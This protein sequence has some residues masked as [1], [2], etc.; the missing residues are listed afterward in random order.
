MT[1]DFIPSVEDLINRIFS[2]SDYSP[3]RDH[4]LAERLGLTGDARRE[5]RAVLRRME[6]AGVA[7]RIR[8]NRW[9]PVAHASQTRYVTGILQSFRRGDARVTVD[10]DSKTE[11]VVDADDLRGALHGDRVQIEP[12]RRPIS[13]SRRNQPPMAPQAGPGGAPVRARIVKV[14]ERRFQ[15]IP[16]LFKR[17]ANYSYLIPEDARL[18]QNIRITSS[19]PGLTPQDNDWVVVELA[20][21]NPNDPQLQGTLVEHLG[22]RDT[23]H[24]DMRALMV[25]HGL[26][27]DFPEAAQREANAWTSQPR[28]EDLA[29]RQDLREKYVVTI[30][31]EQ[32]RDFDDAV[33][34]EPMEG[35]RWRLG[36]HIADVAHFVR[37]GSAVDREALHRGTS[38]YLV[39]RAIPMLPRQLTADVCSLLP[40]MDRLTHTVDMVIGPDATVQSYETYPSVIRSCRRWNYDEVQQVI[41]SHSHAAESLHMGRAERFLL[42]L[43]Q[44]AL[45]LRKR[46]MD[47]G[48]LDFTLPEVKFDFDGN[49][50]IRSVRR[51]GSD[52]AYH[53]IEECMLLANQSVAR[54]LSGARVPAIYRIHEEPD[55]E[56]WESMEED[57]LLMG[58]RLRDHNRD[59]VN[60]MAAAAAQTN[61]GYTVAL[62]ILRNL[63]RAEYSPRCI[64]HFGLAFFPYTHFTSPIRRY[65]DLM[66][67]RM[68]NALERGERPPYSHEQAAAMAKQ[69]T[70]CEREAD[71]AE[72][73]SV[74]MKRADY[75]DQ[76]LKAGEIGPHEAVVTGKIP[77]GF[78]VELTA[79]LQRGLVEHHWFL[80]GGRG[81]GG[82]G[83][84]RMGDTVQVELIH[85]DTYRRLVDFRP[86]GKPRAE[87]SNHRKPRKTES[88]GSRRQRNKER[89]HS[90]R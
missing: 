90:T 17:M 72:R 61:S 44:L 79:S 16:G 43:N 3:L 52:E 15:R 32:A 55:A 35:R 65:P 4:E 29:G 74:D 49:G 64:P 38:V 62:A 88:H 26:S 51:R 47:V 36:V 13:R 50:H 6:S 70:R 78:L 86:A 60:A 39:D 85:V 24:A 34:L 83:R 63:K 42:D 11:Y 58:F 89:R 53:L 37:R 66:V 84:W 23:P 20:P 21:W 30:D 80:R 19:R 25:L 48:A 40:G 14:L 46:R 56:Q 82:N 9:A 69:S 71:E 41:E 68:L 28:P 7:V 54:K 10:G 73:D 8:K 22:T 18:R 57:L 33:S 27:D 1:P 75:F 87:Q 76:Q 77:K 12:D 45:R 59:A 67:H 31:P 81:T 2:S 5:L